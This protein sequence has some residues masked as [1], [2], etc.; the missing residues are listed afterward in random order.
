[1]T[2]RMWVIPFK[3]HLSYSWYVK[4]MTEA[5]LSCYTLTLF[6]LNI[7]FKPMQYFGFSFGGIMKTSAFSYIYIDVKRDIRPIKSMPI[8]NICNDVDRGVRSRACFKWDK[9]RR[10]EETGGHFLNRQDRDNTTVFLSRCSGKSGFYNV[11][12]LWQNKLHYHV[13]ITVC[14]CLVFIGACATVK[15]T[16]KISFD[17]TTTILHPW[18]QHFMSHRLFIKKYICSCSTVFH[19]IC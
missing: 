19:F 6:C 3:M 17:H 5:N 1:M 4:Q 14:S 8:W 16:I 9:T 12:H 13:S 18:N 10:Q 2:R 7:Y 15:L 11:K